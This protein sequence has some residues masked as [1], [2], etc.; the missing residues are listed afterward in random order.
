M[1]DWKGHAVN[2]D[3]SV[4]MMSEFNAVWIHGFCGEHI[5]TCK[6]GNPCWFFDVLWLRSLCWKMFSCK[7]LSNSQMIRSIL[8]IFAFVCWV[9]F[10]FWSILTVKNNPPQSLSQRDPPGLLAS[11]TGSCGSCHLK[12]VGGSTHMRKSS[13]IGRANEGCGVKVQEWQQRWLLNQN[14]V[15]DLL[16]GHSDDGKASCSSFGSSQGGRSAWFHRH[17]RALILDWRIQS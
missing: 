17:K 4:N 7:L 15:I 2:T 9:A 10:L 5:R 1:N 6:S 12:F 3:S 16:H 14:A 11:S 8:D 13:I